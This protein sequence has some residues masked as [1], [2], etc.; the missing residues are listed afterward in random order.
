MK[1]AVGDGRIPA[2][3]DIVADANLQLAEQ[4]G[5]GEVTVIAN[6]EPPLRFDRKMRAI[7][8]AVSADNERL[9]ILCAKAFESVLARDHRPGADSNV[10]GQYTIRPRAGVS[11]AYRIAHVIPALCWA[12]TTWP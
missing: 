5:I 2:N 8:G 11:L 9:G 4:D 3:D 1:V 12:P 7:H 10:R 6:D